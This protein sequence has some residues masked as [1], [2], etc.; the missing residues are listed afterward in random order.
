MTDKENKNTDK[1][2]FKVI[3]FPIH[4]TE[5]AFLTDNIFEIIIKK[6]LTPVPQV[7]E[8]VTGATVYRD[9]IIPIYNTSAVLGYPD[10]ASL[11]GKH[12]II[13]VNHGD[14]FVGLEVD[15]VTDIMETSGVTLK[16]VIVRDLE[17]GI[18]G[19]GIFNDRRFFLLNT[20]K[21]L[22]AK[23]SFDRQVQD[24]IIKKLEGDP[25]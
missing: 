11:P 4:G 3:I 17:S 24:V 1:L 15:K 21:V 25:A 14:R 23:K 9:R 12:T 6:F 16:T 5:Y 20:N 18:E 2:S 19:I 7:S 8:F 13:L 10:S 22:N